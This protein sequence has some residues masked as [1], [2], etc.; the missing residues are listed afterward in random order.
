SESESLSESLF[1]SVEDNDFGCEVW[2]D[3]SSD[4][5]DS[6]DSNDSPDS[7]SD[8]GSWSSCG[9]SGSCDS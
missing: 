9:S 8:S 2:V 5:S 7:S 6:F 3:P 4:S 1:C